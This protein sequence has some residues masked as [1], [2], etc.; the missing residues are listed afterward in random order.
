MTEVQKIWI[1]DSG[2]KFY[3]LGYTHA[4][5]FHPQFNTLQ[6]AICL[7]T[8]SLKVPDTWK[9]RGRWGGEGK[10]KGRKGKRE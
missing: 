2:Y 6:T 7:V 9:K 4:H 5:C 10:E 8:V 1:T 3:P